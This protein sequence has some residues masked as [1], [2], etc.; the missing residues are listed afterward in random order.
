MEKLINAQKGKQKTIY[1]TIHQNSQ[2]QGQQL[3]NQQTR[4]RALLLLL[5]KA[6]SAKMAQALSKLKSRKE[7]AEF[8]ALRAQSKLGS[9]FHKLLRSQEAK[10]RKS[11][12]NLRSYNRR[13]ADISDKLSQKTKSILGRLHSKCQDALRDAYNKLVN[14]KKTRNAAAKSIAKLGEHLKATSLEEAFGILR[15]NKTLAK[16]RE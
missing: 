15:K 7:H 3:R 10:T 5:E 6:Q 1:K 12:S 13:M 16:E 2:Q 4:L 8:D 9:L 14:N 11:V